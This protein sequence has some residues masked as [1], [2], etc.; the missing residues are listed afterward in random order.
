[1][2]QS[3][4]NK[5]YRFLFLIAVACVLIGCAGSLM[6]SAKSERE[7]T[8]AGVPLPPGEPIELENP[9][10]T[11]TVSKL[12]NR[13]C[14]S[15]HQSGGIA[16]FS[17]LTYETVKAMRGSIEN[18]VVNRTMPPPGVDNS[19]ACQTF[20]NATWMSDAEIAS[21]VAWYNAGAPHGEGNGNIAA[22]KIRDLPGPKTILRMP[23]A[24]TPVP[25]AGEVDD[26]RCFI[27]DPNQVENTLITAIQVLPDKV[28][29]VHHVIV[30]KPTSAE[31]QTK[32]EALNGTDGKPGFPCFGAAGVP[33]SIVGLWAPG[34]ESREQRD[35][36]TGKLIGLPLEAGRKLIM[37][38]HY[39]SSGGAQPDQ[40]SVAIKFNKDA[41]P[42]K[43]MVV[44]NFLLNLKPGLADVVDEDTQGNSWFQ[45][46]DEIF[47]RGLADDYINGGGLLSLL[48]AELLGL[49]LN[50]PPAREFKVYGVAPHMHTLG[51]KIAVSKISATAVNQ[52]MADVPQFQFRWQAGYNFVK[53][54]T[55]AATD[56]VKISC[57]FNTSTRTEKTIFGEGTSDEMC[58]AFLLVAL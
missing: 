35:P 41:T 15:C 44:A 21:I 32:A 17:L 29:Q 18:A 16:P 53:P 51:T 54:M 20:S 40:S 37:Q 11:K 46:V 45:T 3:N 12:F 52:C 13:H 23:A 55:L 47:S 19:G 25:P 27:I 24:Y 48:N 50:Q 9:T 2:S 14:T 56:K 49:V 6:E 36:D 42:A 30:F 39:N 1:M 22:P 38:V 7:E 8:A 58:L 34:G 31:S 4:R 33:S 57:H 26:Y 10:Y 28:Q 43:W 5:M